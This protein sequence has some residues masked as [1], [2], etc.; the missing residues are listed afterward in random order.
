MAEGM[1]SGKASKLLL[2]PLLALALWAAA[3]SAAAADGVAAL[4][5]EQKLSSENLGFLVF[6][7]ES[8]AWLESHNPTEAFIPASTAK[9]PMAISA[10]EILGPQH[11]FSTELFMTGEVAGVTLHGDL[12][13]KGGGDPYLATE[14]LL[15][16]LSELGDRTFSS[17]VGNFY[18]DASGYPELAA[19]NPS[20]PADATYNPG[21]SALN[22]NFNGIQ[23]NWKTPEDGPISARAVTSS[24]MMAA[25]TPAIGAYPEFVPLPAG[26]FYRHLATEAGERWQLSEALPR[27]GGERLPVKNPAR[28]AAATLRSLGIV[29]GI[30]L[31]EPKPGRTPHSAVWIAGHDSRPLGEMLRGIL[32]FSN[33]LGA[34]M[35]GLAAAKAAA[36]RPQSAVLGLAESAE[37]I[38]AWFRGLLPDVD[39]RGYALENH[40]GLSSDS[41]ITPAQ[42]AAILGY[43][44]R[45][46]G[47]AADLLPVLPDA[48]ASGEVDQEVNGKIEILAKSG[49]INYGRALAGYITAASG[50]RI[51]FA[52][53]VSDIPRR[54]I[55][56]QRLAAH[57]T[58][59]AA[60]RSWLRRARKLER[61]LL[62]RWAATY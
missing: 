33:N 11:R 17:V 52:V 46:R 47:T 25:E 3:Q 32:K 55:Y 53:F 37:L 39:W 21:V 45:Q 40:S 1:L 5:Q 27:E 9:L 12:Y 13:L 50:K 20:Q 26:Q 61:A 59:D 19:I 16:L 57:Q 8:G 24:D 42:M 30:Y 62:K 51:G 48:R 36:H 15:S 56:D 34:E 28:N 22:L 35:I 44:Y 7:P 10:L 6:D 2:A 14:D 54:R 41:R 31:P 23:L 38:G 18:Y 4:L 43:A 58:D 29:E 49:T 60:A